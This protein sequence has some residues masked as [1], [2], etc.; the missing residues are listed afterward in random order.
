MAGRVDDAI[1]E[2]ESLPGHDDP[3]AAAWLTDARRYNDARR[4]L[5]RI[6]TAAILEPG[7]NRAPD[8]AAAAPAPTPAPKAQPAP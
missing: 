8:T 6:E 4:A 7:Q 5:D 1:A 2:V 3:M